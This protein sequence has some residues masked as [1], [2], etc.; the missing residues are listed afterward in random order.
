[1]PG[2]EVDHLPPFSAEINKCSYTSTTQYVR[3]PGA[4]Q[5]GECTTWNFKT[6][7]VLTGRANDEVRC[8]QA[9]VHAL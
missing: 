4:D 6:S 5:T 1:M 9:V 7:P 2:R 3:Q 8:N